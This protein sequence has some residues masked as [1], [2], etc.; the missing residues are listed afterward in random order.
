M[1]AIASAFLMHTGARHITF[2]LTDAQKALLSHPGSKL[3]IML[4]MFY[5]STRNVLW[6]LVLICVY[7]VAVNVLLNEHHKLNVFSP[8]WL[9]GRGLAP[10]LL[11]EKLDYTELYKKNLSAIAQY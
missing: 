8:G 6:S 2:D 3:V 10:S 9:A 5:I 11:E 7:V 4:A 1:L